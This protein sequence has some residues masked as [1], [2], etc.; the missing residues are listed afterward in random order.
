MR[1]ELPETGAVRVACQGNAGAECCIDT[2]EKHGCCVSFP[3]VLLS[4]PAAGP[5]MPHCAHTY[6]RCSERP[7][8]LGKQM[9]PP[10]PRVT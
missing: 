2:A 5:L 6:A 1:S 7:V 9:V 8:H 10:W 3:F 4:P